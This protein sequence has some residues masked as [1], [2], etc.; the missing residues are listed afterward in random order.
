MGRLVLLVAGMLSLCPISSH[1]AEAVRPIRIRVA[2]ASDTLTLNGS[3]FL[4]NRTLKFKSARSIEIK[5][6]END[7]WEILVP[8]HA[9]QTVSALVLNLEAEDLHHESRRI[10][11][12]IEIVR[13]KGFQ[14]SRRLDVIATLPLEKYLLDVVA[15]EV[16]SKWPLETLKSQAVAAR[17]YALVT[18]KERYGKDYDIDSTTQAQVFQY[19]QHKR[20]EGTR[21]IIRAVE[22]TRDQ[23]LTA[24]SG[25]LLKTYFH[26]HCGGETEDAGRV[27]GQPDPRFHPV[28]DT[29][30]CQTSP[31]GK[32]SAQISPHELVSLVRHSLKKSRAPLAAASDEFVSL[33]TRLKQNSQR[34]EEIEVS[35]IEKAVRFSVQNFREKLGFTRIKSG[36]FDVRFKDG[37]FILEGQGYGHGAG[38]CQTGSRWMGASGKRYDQILSRYYPSSRLVR[39]TDSVEMNMTKN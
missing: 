6:L 34:I 15:S 18:Q 8:N 10:P 31:S 11:D 13:P 3:D 29:E 4:L 14:T 20:V 26:A 22:R 27:W 35:T 33:A 16:P 17:T 21:N 39:I 28:M 23:V 2:T 24:P 30:S 5:A 32:W 7:E 36:I 9:P 37:F 19:L 38:L 1:S 12:S 25:H